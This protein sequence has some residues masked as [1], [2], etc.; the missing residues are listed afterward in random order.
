MPGPTISSVSDSSTVQTLSTDD[1]YVEEPT[2][3]ARHNP[4]IHQRPRD[5]TNASVMMDSKDFG[6]KNRMNTRLT[7]PN[8]EVHTVTSDNNGNL[9]YGDRKRGVPDLFLQ[10]SPV[11]IVGRDA[12][13]PDS[14]V[15]PSA[16]MGRLV[17]THDA[18]NPIN[19]MLSENFKVGGTGT[20]R[21]QE[22]TMGAGND[23]QP[24]FSSVDDA[25][26]LNFTYYTSKSSEFTHYDKVAKRN[27]MSKLSERVLDISK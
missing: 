9:N 24:S 17:N 19:A 5:R 25:R 11:P 12:Y 14:F 13:G 23:M 1:I 6:P 18:M 27:F 20:I 16:S 15:M 10:S 3:V 7:E 4:V 21:D 26:G 2:L 8:P 22:S